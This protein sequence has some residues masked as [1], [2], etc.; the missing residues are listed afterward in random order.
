LIYNN[1][2]LC[3]GRLNAVDG[4][5]IIICRKLGLALFLVACGVAE[6]VAGAAEVNEAPFAFVLDALL[7]EKTHFVLAGALDLLLKGID[8]FAL[9]RFG[10]EVGERGEAA[11]DLD[12]GRGGL[13]EVGGGAAQ[14]VESVRAT[15]G[16]EL[17]PL[18]AVGARFGWIGGNHIRFIWLIIREGKNF[19][20]DG[21]I[22]GGSAIG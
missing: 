17:G 14:H 11:D 2:P 6:E 13:E 18:I 5:K 15:F 4:F 20:A 1:L 16:L 21:G 22:M 10:A 19:D 3:L 7:A 12:L 8:K 9:A